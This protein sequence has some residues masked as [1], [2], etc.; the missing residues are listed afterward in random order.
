M[1]GSGCP[2]RN[3]A[4]EDTSLKTE[5]FMMVG[6][7][8]SNNNNNHHNH[9]YIIMVMVIIIGFTTIVIIIKYVYDCGSGES[10]LPTSTR[11]LYS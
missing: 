10:S 8:S 7:S 1:W 11:Y 4:P 2:E 6:D 3:T 5:T 9:N